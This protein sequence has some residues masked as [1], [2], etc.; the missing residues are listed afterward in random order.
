MK[1]CMIHGQ[2]HKGSTY[3][4]G[5]MLADRLG[6]TVTE[7]FLPRDFGEFC[8]GCTQCF[9]KSEKL[10]P[11]YEKLR[12]ITEA[13]D[14]ADLLIFTSPVYVYHCTGSMK[15]LLDHYGWRWMLHR[16]EKSMFSKQAVAVTTAAGAGMRT[17]CRDIADSFF[18]WGV[19]RYYSFGTAVYATSWEDVNSFKK[20]MIKKRI[21]RLARRIRSEQGRV[22]PAFKTRAFFELNAR[23]MKGVSPADKSFW[24][25]NGWT[26]GA[27]P[28][29]D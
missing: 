12:P 1:I 28:W 3:A 17:A 9:M 4:I 18:F 8:C 13:I 21:D 16:P 29:K 20:R 25:K 22:F 10:C 23:L 14:E 7:F 26:R 6:G 11:H 27:R 19:G 24:R 15:A 5:K 2:N